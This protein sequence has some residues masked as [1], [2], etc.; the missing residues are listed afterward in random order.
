[1]KTRCILT[2]ML[3]VGSV[4]SSGAQTPAAKPAPTE[5]G[6]IHGRIT[7]AAT[8]KPVRRARVTIRTAS[9]TAGFVIV[10]Q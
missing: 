10:P 8:G 6:A 4:L 3:F 5:T 9:E 1:M 2:V 7:A